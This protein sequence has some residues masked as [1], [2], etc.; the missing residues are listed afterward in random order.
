M[1]KS[2]GFNP[3]FSTFIPAISATNLFDVVWRVF[4]SCI[5]AI[6]VTIW[7][8]SKNKSCF[9]QCPGYVGIYSGHPRAVDTCGGSWALFGYPFSPKMIL[10]SS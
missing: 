2:T 4:D 3:N 9:T 10:M 1:R 8:W 6:L 7:A 5:R